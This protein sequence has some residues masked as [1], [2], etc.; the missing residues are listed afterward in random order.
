MGMRIHM[1]R[2]GQTTDHVPYIDDADLEAEGLA[3]EMRDASHGPH[4]PQTHILSR[5]VLDQ[6]KD[7]DLLRIGLLGP[8]M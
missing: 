4:G 5:Q 7:E 1:G 8:M 2:S 6:A 3:E